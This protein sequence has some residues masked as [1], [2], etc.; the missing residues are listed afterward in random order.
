ML[1]RY[2]HK[3]FPSQGFFLYINLVFFF[4]NKLSLI[5]QEIQHNEQA[6]KQGIEITKQ[7]RH[8]QVIM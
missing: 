2:L 4:V 6:L 3:P 7:K 1:R 5:C 8:N